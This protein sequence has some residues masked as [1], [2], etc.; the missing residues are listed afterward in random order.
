MLLKYTRFFLSTKPLFLVK[1][2]KC[3]NLSAK[4]MSLVSED[5]EFAWVIAVGLP[6]SIKAVQNNGLSSVG[7]VSDSFSVFPS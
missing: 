4:C 3:D 2:K 6:S 5:P 1:T 7:D